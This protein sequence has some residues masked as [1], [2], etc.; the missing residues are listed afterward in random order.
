MCKRYELMKIIIFQGRTAYAQL[1][2]C[3]R[4]KQVTTNLNNNKIFR[5]KEIDLLNDISNIF[6]PIRTAK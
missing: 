3:M 4:G 5:N 1:S 2:N 6:K